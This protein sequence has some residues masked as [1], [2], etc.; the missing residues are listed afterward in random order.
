MSWTD[1]LA[2]VTGVGSLVAA[3]AALAVA[4]RAKRL[5]EEANEAQKRAEEQALRTERREFV[6]AVD[7]FALWY[8]ERV[9]GDGGPDPGPADALLPAARA[10]RLYAERLKQPGAVALAKW[11]LDLLRRMYR[12]ESGMRPFEEMSV[13]SSTASQWVLD[14]EVDLGEAIAKVDGAYGR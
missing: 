1:L 13:I 7:T 9:V 2:I 4:R 8:S 3:L 5:Q 6:A 12:G 11:A 14:G 10:L